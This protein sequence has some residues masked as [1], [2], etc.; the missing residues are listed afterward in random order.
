MVALHKLQPQGKDLTMKKIVE[1]I[2]MCFNHRPVFTTQVHGPRRSRA[3]CFASLAPC[4]SSLA[5]L[6]PPFSFPRAICH[7]VHR[8]S[9]VSRQGMEKEDEEEDFLQCIELLTRRSRGLECGHGRCVDTCMLA[10]RLAGI[11]QSSHILLVVACFLGVQV[12]AVV[13]Q[14]LLDQNPL[15]ELYMRTVL[16]AL[17]ASPTLTDFVMGILQRLISKQVCALKPCCHPSSLS[18]GCPGVNIFAPKRGA[19]APVPWGRRLRTACWGDC[20]RCGTRQAPKGIDLAACGSTC[21]MGD[22][23]SKNKKK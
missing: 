10:Y 9:S 5:P 18:P 12:L 20:T 13:L 23:F 14:R 15:P 7:K 6:A 2:E 22:V 4:F 21:S 8:D 3:P 11:S 1:A 17:K 19:L 16:L